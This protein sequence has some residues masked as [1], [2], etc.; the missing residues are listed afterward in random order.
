MIIPPPRL[1]NFKYFRNKLKKIFKTFFNVYDTFLLKNAVFTQ[2][3]ENIVDIYQ[4]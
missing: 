1:I 2:L 4:K 3:C